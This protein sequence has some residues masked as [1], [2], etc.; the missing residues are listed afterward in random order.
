MT[1]PTFQPDQW[2]IYKQDQ[3]G[4]FGQIIGASFDGEAWN[5]SLRGPAID[6]TFTAVTEL[7]ITHTYENGSWIE[8]NR[9]VASHA[10]AYT[11]QN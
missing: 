5:Y 2:V 1:I 6:T 7:D 10:S 11:D 8:M 9:E 3:T 4:G